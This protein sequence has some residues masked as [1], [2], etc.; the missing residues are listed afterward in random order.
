MTPADIQLAQSLIDQELLIGPAPPSETSFTIPFPESIYF[1]PQTQ[2]FQSID[3]STHQKSTILRQQ[4]LLLQLWLQ[5]HTF[6][7]T[8]T[9]DPII[10]QNQRSSRINQLQNQL[11]LEWKGYF[12]KNQQFLTDFNSQHL[13]I[14]SLHHDYEFYS[15]LLQNENRAIDS[16]ADYWSQLFQSLQGQHFQLQSVFFD[17][18]NASK[19]Q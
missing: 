17:H 4:A 16:R 9:A 2:R 3:T 8:T 10:T 1:N 14:R 6:T 13:K 19:I 11:N 15:Q 12:N 7:S 5:Q 18:F